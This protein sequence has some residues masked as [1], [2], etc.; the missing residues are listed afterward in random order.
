MATL[1]NNNSAVALLNEGKFIESIRVLKS[2]L[3]ELMYHF[4]TA[5]T[6]ADE[7]MTGAT[8]NNP[9]IK[10]HLVPIHLQK[11]H[12]EGTF[13]LYNRAVAFSGNE[14]ESQHQQQQPLMLDE[15]DELRFTAATL[16]NT[17]LS[18]HLMAV[19]K[20]ENQAENLTKALSQYKLAADVLERIPCCSC[21]DDLL[22]LAITNNMG[23]AYSQMFKI[24][25]A[26]SC[27]QKIE[28]ILTYSK[29]G[30]ELLDTE[31][32]DFQLL[33]FLG[34]NNAVAAPAA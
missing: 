33:V 1:A 10:F 15:G 24:P 6:S 26:R 7:P 20:A 32:Q 11:C 4:Q 13:S 8:N 29:P 18:Y 30:I 23:F 14:D 9:D 5:T 16:Y 27:V 28:V 22:L 2:S 31:I 12:F 3:Q 21:F 17:A 34:E 19:N 25:E